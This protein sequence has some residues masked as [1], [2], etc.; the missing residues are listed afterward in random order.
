MRFADYFGRAFSDVTASSFP[1][2][3]TFRE[4]SVA[5]ISD[6]SSSKVVSS[7]SFYELST[8]DKGCGKN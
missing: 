1:W 8:L 5:K 4:T 7:T 2:M 6:V 3:K